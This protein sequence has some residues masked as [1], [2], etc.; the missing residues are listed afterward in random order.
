MP[1]SG[2]TSSGRTSSPSDRQ[3]SPARSADQESQSETLPP[4]PEPSSEIEYSSMSSTEE[5]QT[6][7]I[8]LSEVMPKSP[9]FSDN[10]V[11]WLTS[12]SGVVVENLAACVASSGQ[13]LAAC[14]VNSWTSQ[15]ASSAP[16]AAGSAA[17]F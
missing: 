12:D 9:A 2:D 13:E 16:T 6:E 11:V 15:I 10:V 3:I 4:P 7:D 17:F 5:P 8:E 14:E 1:T